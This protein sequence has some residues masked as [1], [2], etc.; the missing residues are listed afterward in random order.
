MQNKEL[1]NTSLRECPFCGGNN[2]DV[3][4]WEVTFQGDYFKAYCKD[5]DFELKPQRTEEEAIEAWNTRKSYIDSIVDQLKEKAF[6]GS[7]NG[8]CDDELLDLNDAIE[9]VKG[10]AE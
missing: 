2:V 9:I 10:G 3:F 6:I 7:V 5:C 4:N 1:K 8:G